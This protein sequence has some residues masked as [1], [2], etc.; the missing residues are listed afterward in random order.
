MIEKNET[1]GRNE[2]QN[3]TGEMMQRDRKTRK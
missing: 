2:P 3:D 1:E